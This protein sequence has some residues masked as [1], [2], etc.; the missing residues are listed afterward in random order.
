MVWAAH[1][2]NNVHLAVT[3]LGQDLP[4]TDIIPSNCRSTGLR[5]TNDGQRQ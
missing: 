2:P 1:G 3:H 5:Y 4:R